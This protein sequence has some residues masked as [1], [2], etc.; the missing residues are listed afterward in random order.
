MSTL[1][2]PL[3]SESI[4]IFA[5]TVELEDKIAMLAKLLHSEVALAI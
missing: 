3:R 5:K 4:I 1:A 2:N